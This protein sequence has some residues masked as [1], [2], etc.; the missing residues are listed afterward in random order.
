MT[1]AYNEEGIAKIKS[2]I[3]SSN[4]TART[5]LI[6]LRDDVLSTIETLRSDWKTPAGAAFLREI[7]ENWVSYVDKVS[8]ILDDFI[9]LLDSVA[10]AFNQ[11]TAESDQ[12]NFDGSV[13]VPSGN[14]TLP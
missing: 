12:I 6:A 9:T 4:D 14:I 1:L 5:D 11:L 2:N 13:Y 7:D 10:N 8:T 3:I